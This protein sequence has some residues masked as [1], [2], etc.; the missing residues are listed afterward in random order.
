MDAGILLHGLFR[1]HDDQGDRRSVG[2]LAAL[3]G[4]EDSV[5]AI[6]G[7]EDLLDLLANSFVDI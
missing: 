3:F 7:G 5:D 6:T 4:E 1:P 2:D